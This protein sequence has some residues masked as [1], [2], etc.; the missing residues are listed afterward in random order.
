MIG[1]FGIGIDPDDLTSSDLLKDLLNADQQPPNNVTFDVNAVV[2][3]DRILV[4]KKHATNPDFDFEEMTID[5]GADP[6]GCTS[7]RDTSDHA[8]RRPYPARA[9]PIP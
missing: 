2:V 4:G 8:R 6:G 9:I 7:D 3:G 5:T 1:A